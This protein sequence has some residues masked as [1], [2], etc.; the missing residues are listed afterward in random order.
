MKLLKYYNL[1]NKYYILKKKEQD[2]IF[3]HHV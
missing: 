2:Y 1:V 3:L